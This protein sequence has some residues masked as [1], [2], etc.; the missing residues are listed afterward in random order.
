MPDATTLPAE[1]LKIIKQ[2]EAVCKLADLIDDAR[3]RHAVEKLK[4][5]IEAFKNPER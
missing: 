4:I 5:A 3:A 1:I 2:A